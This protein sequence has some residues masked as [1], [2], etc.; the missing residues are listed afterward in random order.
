MKYT[1]VIGL[2]IHI[3]L[4]TKSKMFCSCSND[5][6]KKDPNSVTC[7]TCLGLPGALPVPNEE[8][9]RKTQ[10][11]GLSLECELNENSSFAR[12]NYFYPDLPKGYQITQFSDPLCV[13]GHLNTSLGKIAIRRVHLEEDTGKSI[14]IKEGT[15]LDFNKSGVPLAE[16]VTEP[17]IKN[18]EQAVEFCKKIRELVRFLD[19]S[20]GDM[21]KGNMRLELNISLRE[22]NDKSLPNYRVEIK[23]INSFKFLK[24]AIEYEIERQEKI[25]SL[26]EKVE[27]ETRGWNENTKKTVSQRKKEMENDY[28][29]FPEPDIPPMDFSK[30]YFDILKNELSAKELANKDNSAEASKTS[31]KAKGKIEYALNKKEELSK[32]VKSVI[33]DNPI[34]VKDY[35]AGKEGALQFLIGLVM[36]KTAGKADPKISSGLLRSFLK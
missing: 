5:I 16:L 35:K 2:E 9:I 1:P 3:Q 22:D 8:A 34:P 26:G 7:P 30:E 6:W 12:K 27:Q 10:L 32:I 11:L 23:N 24:T 18:S 36:R 20:N 13:N 14:H 17:D 21:E 19:I 15:L 29:Y 4:N 31:K 25:L 33:K 28:R